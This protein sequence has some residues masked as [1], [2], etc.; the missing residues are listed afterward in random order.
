MT[1]FVS[2]AE[3]KKKKKNHG[4]SYSLK[5]RSTVHN[6]T[7][8]SKSNWES[9]IVSHTCNPALQRLGLEKLRSPRSA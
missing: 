4:D 3:K 1:L 2:W 5:L 7:Q 6:V 9:G 8:S